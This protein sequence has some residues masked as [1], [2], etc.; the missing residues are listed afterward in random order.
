MS[1]YNILGIELNHDE[2]GLVN[3]NVVNFH[4]SF[5]SNW[6]EDVGG[7]GVVENWNGDRN[8]LHDYLDA[9]DKILPLGILPE[10]CRA[11]RDFSG[12]SKK[13]GLF[14]SHSSNSSSK[15]GSFFLHYL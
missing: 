9:T 7:W 14:L 12:S 6:M 11:P 1:E 15:T 13:P 4:A 5:I 10:K 3:A 8:V 2:Y